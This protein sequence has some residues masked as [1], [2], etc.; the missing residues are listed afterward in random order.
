MTLEKDI[1][2]VP[3]NTR[4]EYLTFNVNEVAFA[5]NSLYI[6]SIASIEGVTPI[7]GTNN[8][9]DGVIHFRGTTIPVI[10]LGRYLFNKDS[11]GGEQKYCVVCKLDDKCY[12]FRIDSVRSIVTANSLDIIEVDKLLKSS[13]T[14]LDGFLADENRN[15]TEILNIKN[16]IRQCE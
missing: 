14:M 15:I 10:N 12:A 6:D 3:K 9:T 8:M 4:L 13:C 16:I 5:I 2:V 7:P 11:D 1:E